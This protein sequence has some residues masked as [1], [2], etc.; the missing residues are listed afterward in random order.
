[1][2]VDA[3]LKLASGKGTHQKLEDMRIELVEEAFI[4]E[5]IDCLVGLKRG[6]AVTCPWSLPSRRIAT[7]SIV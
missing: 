2:I 4:K 5:L 3:E 1:M 7:K 6:D